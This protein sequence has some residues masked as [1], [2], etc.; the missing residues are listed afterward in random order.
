MGEEIHRPSG[1]HQGVRGVE[2]AGDADHDLVDPRSLQ[3]L[4]ESLDLDVVRFIAALVPCGGVRGDI[5]EP[6][7]F[8][9]E[10]ETPPDRFDIEGNAPE[11][12]ESVY[13]AGLGS[14]PDF[15]GAMET[16]DYIREVRGE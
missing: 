8:P 16:A 5:G 6:C 1:D 9:L 2:S 15:T 7:I 4:G 12:Q 14:Q 11:F 3:A 13:R 10:E